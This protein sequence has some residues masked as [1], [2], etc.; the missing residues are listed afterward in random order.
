MLFVLL[1]L[2]RVLQHNNEV[3]RTTNVVL[4]ATKVLNVGTK[5]NCRLEN[6]IAIVK[7]N[8]NALIASRLNLLVPLRCHSKCAMQKN[9]DESSTEASK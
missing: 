3:I 9:E 1:E 8:C 2:H 6:K 5:E 4:D 7:N